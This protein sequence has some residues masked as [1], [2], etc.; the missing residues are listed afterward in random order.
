MKKEY[1]N[2]GVSQDAAEAAA[3][4]KRKPLRESVYIKKS[5]LANMINHC[6]QEL[7]YEACG[8]LSGRLGKNE[9]QWIMNNTERSRTSFAMDLGEM[10]RTLNLIKQKSE[11]MT[12]IYHSHP[13]APPVPSRNDIIH[14][15]YPDAAYFIISLASG[16]PRVKCY[17]IRN[18]KVRALTI[19]E[20]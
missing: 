2:P 17:R 15:Y 9:T 12:G 18:E 20:M 6:Q 1:T 10:T 13:T 4:A 14:A 19:I 7:P 5:V 3:D 11:G 16:K 8:L